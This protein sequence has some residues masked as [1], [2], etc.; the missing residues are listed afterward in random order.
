MTS[1]QLSLI[2]PL[3]T[4]LSPPPEGQVLTDSQWITLMAIAD[5]VIPS[6]GVSS[7]SSD[8]NLC[9]APSEY[10][11]AVESIGHCLPAQAD[12]GLTQRYLREN[13]SSVP[14]FKDLVRRM[15]AVSIKEDARKGIRVILSAL[16]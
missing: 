14:G 4:P 12:P 15:L 1:T 13:A 10:A 3:D 5:A 2:A 7:T 6:I 11:S 16:E 8:I 9:L